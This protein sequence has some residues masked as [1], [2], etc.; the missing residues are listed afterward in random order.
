MSI[1][2]H[3]IA[4][5]GLYGLYAGEIVIGSIILFGGG[6]LAS[7]LFF[8]L[9]SSGVMTMVIS[10]AYGYHNEFTPTVLFLIFVG[11]ILACFNTRRG[12]RGYD[13]GWGFDFD[14]S[15]SG[16]GSD[17]GGGDCGGGGD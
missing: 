14:F 9:R 12:S 7:K 1:I 10:I 16:S 8:C 17:F 3:L 2:G 11:F 6:F 13:N 4:L 15:S 5:L